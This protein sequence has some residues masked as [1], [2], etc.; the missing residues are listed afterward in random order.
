MRN[1]T[2][3]NMDAESEVYKRWDFVYELEEK[4]LK[5]K[6]NMHWLD[7]GDKNNTSFHRGATAREIVNSVKEIECLDGEVVRTP[8]QIKIEAERHF[9]EFLQFQPSNYSGI[10]VDVLQSL[11]PYRC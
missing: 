3:Q 7:V 9:R 8:E 4:F 2:Q 5:Q 10:D 11:L 1:T 6:S